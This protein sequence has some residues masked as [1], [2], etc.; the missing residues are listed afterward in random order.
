MG[1]ALNAKDDCFYT[2]EEMIAK[3]SSDIR[4]E[5]EVER[6]EPLFE[7]EAS[8]DVFRKRHDKHCIR[9][10]E[11]QNY[12][13][14]CYLGIDAG[15]TTTKIALVAEDGSLLH[16][17]YSNN[18]GSPLNTAVEAIKDIYRQL[19]KSAHIVRSCSTGYGEALMKAALLLDDG[20]VETVAHYHAAAFFNRFCTA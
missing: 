11:L 10:A 16:S 20:E 12:S 5:F 15:S 18:N 8:Y 2:M 13:G 4:M 1:S 14:N 9:T 7:D 3:L 17:F 19:P 6:M